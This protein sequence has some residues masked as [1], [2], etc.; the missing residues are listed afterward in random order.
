M[1]TAEQIKALLKSHG[2]G[3]DELDGGS[4]RNQLD[5]GTGNDRM[6]GG[7]GTDYL[8][9]GEGDDDLAGLSST[10]LIDGGAGFD[11]IRLSLDAPDFIVG[12]GQGDKLVLPDG[13]VVEDLDFMAA[14]DEAGATNHLAVMVGGNPV[15]ILLGGG[16][17]ERPTVIAGGGGDDTPRNNLG[18]QRQHRVRGPAKLECA[19]FLPVFLFHSHAWQ[20]RVGQHRRS[21]DEGPNP[22]LRH[23]DVVDR[24]GKASHHVPRGNDMRW[25]GAAA[26]V[27]PQMRATF[28]AAA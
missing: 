19:G 28:Q 7:D 10:D 12:A 25:P 2:D 15:A 8:Y 18:R 4:G 6:A 27:T 20:T 22:R 1:A 5:G 23:P 24:D 16:T 13:V 26:P 9:G 21:P 14:S 17:G 3:N 11:T